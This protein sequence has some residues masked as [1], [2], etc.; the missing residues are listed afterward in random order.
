MCIAVALH[1]AGDSDCAARAVTMQSRRARNVVSEDSRK[2]NGQLFFMSHCILPCVAIKVNSPQRS[3]RVD[4]FRGPII[5]VNRIAGNGP[6][7][8]LADE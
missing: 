3:R 8:V 6:L 4:L 7:D 2:A 5:K 1:A